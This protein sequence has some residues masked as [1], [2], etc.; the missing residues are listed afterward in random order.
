MLNFCLNLVFGDG[1][2]QTSGLDITQGAFDFVASTQRGNDSWLQ[3]A[4]VDPTGNGVLMCESSGIAKSFDRRANATAWEMQLH[5][6]KINTIDC[7][8]SLSFIL[9]ISRELIGSIPPRIRRDRPKNN[10]S[11]KP[12]LTFLDK[13]RVSILIGAC[14]SQRGVM[15][16]LHVNEPFLAGI[17]GGG[18]VRDL[19]F[20]GRRTLV[21]VPPHLTSL[22]PGPLPFS[23]FHRLQATRWNPT[24]S[25]RYFGTGLSRDR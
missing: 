7:I 1:V 9:T 5:E 21:H 18:G 10:I 25:R 13:T 16:F 24:T 6:K 23:F 15:Q 2:D 17:S 11:T 22:S 12:V 3:Y 14:D 20:L 19:F 4:T 8:L